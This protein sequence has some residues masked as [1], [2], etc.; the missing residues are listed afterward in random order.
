MARSTLLVGFDASS[1]ADPRA[2]GVGRYTRELLRALLR[3]APP[4]MEFLVLGNSLRHGARL[5]RWRPITEAPNAR[6]VVRRWPGPMLLRSWK[7]LG[8]PSWEALAGTR[9]C[10]VLHSPAM[11]LPPAECPRVVTVHDLGFLRE[12][13]PSPLAGGYFRETFPRELPRCAAI[14]TPSMHTA[15]DVQHQYGLPPDRVHAVPSGLP[16]AFLSDSQ[17]KPAQARWDV[18]GVTA[19]VE[20]KRPGLL[21][22][23]L[24]RLEARRPGLRMAVAGWGD[25][26]HPFPPGVYVYPRLPDP[27]LAFLY[28]S[29]GVVLLTTREEGFGFPVLESFA[30]RT[31]VVCGR[32]SA[33]AEI[34]G[35]F[36][37]FVEEETPEDY[38]AGVLEVL[39]R[40]PDALRTAAARRHALSFRW[41]ETARQM[42]SIYRKAAGR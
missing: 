38:T 24:R 30:S 32:H 20:R 25:G 28:R 34:A 33:L 15:E 41:E 14:V 1:A 6:L 42:V 5:R 40:Q 8:W 39:A 31:P 2:T 21:A 29:A 3:I 22:E 10:A 35:G 27:E 37:D 17:R 4:D 16:E 19:P 12:R 11:Y 9:E 36:A 26:P 7:S 23:V 18:L 13:M